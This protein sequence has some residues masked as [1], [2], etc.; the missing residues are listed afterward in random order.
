MYNVGSE[1]EIKILEFSMKKRLGIVGF[2]DNT[3]LHY[4][5]LRRSDFFEVV[6]IFSYDKSDINCKVKIYHDLDEFLFS[7]KPEILV[8]GRDVK[9]QDIF[10]KCTKICKFILFC[11]PI[12][13]NTA[14]INEMKYCSK[15]DNV[16]AMVGFFTRF[17]QAVISLKKAILKESKIF[18]ITV[19][20]VFGD[21][22]GFRDV[23][24]S[25]IDLVRF[26]SGSE[27]NQSSKFEASLSNEKSSKN[28]SYQ[29]KTKNEVL[30]N[31]QLLRTNH[32][33]RYVVEIACESGIYF[34]D[35]INL[36]LYKYTPMGQQNLKVD[37]D[38][39][40]LK[41]AYEQIFAIFENGDFGDIATLDDAQKVQEICE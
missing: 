20:C 3:K 12:A 32:L 36:K 1:S 29:L 2:D 37:C 30:A 34:G 9:H 27:I 40:P 5:E 18:A 10:S 26:L 24:V 33:E 28:I 41:I 4:N 22:L 25:N 35:L 14:L 15:S 38:I 8:I 31:L 39:S 21:N 7:Q 19:N 13:K 16:K 6:G 11:S 23:T 17:N